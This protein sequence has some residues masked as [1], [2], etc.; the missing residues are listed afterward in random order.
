[1]TYSFYVVDVEDTHVVLGVQW[2]YSIGKYTTNYQ[3]MEMK[4]QG[5]DGK[6][7]VFRGSLFTENGGS[8]QVG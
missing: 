3:A 4:F 1:M 2:I 5:P 7:V 8:A 6:R